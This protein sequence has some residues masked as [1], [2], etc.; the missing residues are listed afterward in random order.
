[1]ELKT[2]LIDALEIALIEDQ[3]KENRKEAFKELKYYEDLIMKL[4]VSLGVFEASFIRDAH[5]DHLIEFLDL[6]YTIKKEERFRELKEVL[7]KL[8]IQVTK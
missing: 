6:A 4:D 2:T 8:L 3:N 5:K 1:M 7:N